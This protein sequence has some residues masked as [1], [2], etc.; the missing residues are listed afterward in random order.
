[1]TVA[2]AVTITLGLKSSD[3][4]F[5]IT[6][7]LGGEPLKF[8]K[9]DRLNE[10]L[11]QRSTLRN[12]LESILK[13]AGTSLELKW[14]QTNDVLEQ[15][16]IQG[17]NILLH[18]VGQDGGKLEQIERFFR[19]AFEASA[20]DGV[21]APD[22]SLPIVRIVAPPDDVFANTFPFELLPFLNSKELP[23]VEDVSGLAEVMGA[24]LGFSAIVDRACFEKPPEL[25]LVSAGN[26]GP[27]KLPIK[28]FVHA[29]LP[30]ALDEAA[31]LRRRRDLIVDGPWPTEDVVDGPV[32]VAR[33]ISNP[34]SLL[35]GDRREPVDQ[36]QHFSCHCETMT[37]TGDHY[38][39]LQ[40]KQ[41][42]RIDVQL[43]ELPARR[44]WAR[45]AEGFF[46]C[47]MPLVLF[48]NCGGAA[49]D[50]KQIGSFVEFFSV[51]NK[52]RGF[53]GTQ[54]RIPDRL[55]EAFSKQ[56]YTNL[57]RR[58][59]PV[60]VAVAEA[61]RAVALGYQNPLSLFYIHYGSPWLRVSET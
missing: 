53:I 24:F 28:L 20:A 32:F 3:D 52:N 36:V 23:G 17:I 50:P 8:G 9:R 25:K 38:F 45:R 18:V 48:N 41:G 42:K 33:H 57:L 43:S 27:A 2:A 39:S 5:F 15:L 16:Q 49:V 6:N 40:P 10:V 44:F 34:C 12:H 7:M 51:T 55:A 61:R 60:G 29:A 1:M 14:K 13:V 22:G 47:E 4:A 46:E 54:S 58:R 30:G 11:F 21:N 56:F 35:C 26:A 31:Y 37:T 19:E 59:Q